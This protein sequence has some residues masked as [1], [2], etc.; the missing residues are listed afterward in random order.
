MED[1]ASEEIKTIT[2]TQDIGTPSIQLNVREFIPQD[3][4]CQGKTWV[5]QGVRHYYP[6]T[7]Y[8]IANMHQTAQMY[9]DRVCTQIEPVIDFYIPEEDDFLRSTYILAHERSKSETVSI[10]PLKFKHI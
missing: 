9:I 4:D 6:C 8:A 3:G 7:N 5:T 1:W 2:L 10:P